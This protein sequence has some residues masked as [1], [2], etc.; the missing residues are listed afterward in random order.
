MAERKAALRVYE[1]ENDNSEIRQRDLKARIIKK[2]L[3]IKHFTSVEELAAIVSE[4]WK[5]IIDKLYPPLDRISVELCE[6]IQ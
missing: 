3:P 5:I 2:G 6:Y 1:S 4:D